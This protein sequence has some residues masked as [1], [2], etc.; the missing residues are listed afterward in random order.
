VTAK[1]YLLSLPERLL[2]SALG[3]SAGIAR[4]VGEVVIPD[5][6]KR[7]QLYGNLVDTTLRFLIEQV[8]QVENAYPQQEALANDFLTR[9]SVGNAIEAL[10]V[11]AFRASPVWVLA[12]LADV[13]GA[14]RQLIPEIADA[15]K[16]QGL[17][18]QETQFDTVDQLLDGLERTSSR[19]AG[20]INTPP[21][22]VTSLREEWRALREEA[23]TLQP[24]HLPTR[25]TLAGLWNQLRAAAAQ[26][27]RSIFETSSM[28]AVSAVKALPEG[29]R[30][31]SASALIGASRTGQI[32]AAGLLDHYRTT[33]DEIRRVGYGTFAAR[34]LGPY[35]RAAVNQFSPE[36]RTLTERFLDRRRGSSAP[37]ETSD[38]PAMSDRPSDLPD[39]TKGH[40]T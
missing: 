24:Q 8:G 33:L 3:L 22:D 12:A 2:R 4:E 10:G 21:L 30:W 6:V 15:L 9:R 29:A 35:V 1:T 39:R 36:H 19:L 31:L 40:N 23:G 5:R 25:D 27:E 34:Q 14:G 28:M 26:H 16:E 38:P 18:D 32:V 7:T 17:L 11:V 20:T 37:P 13:C